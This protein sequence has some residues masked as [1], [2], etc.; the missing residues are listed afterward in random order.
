MIQILGRRR[1]SFHFWQ[2]VVAEIVENFPTQASGG[3]LYGHCRNQNATC[4]CCESHGVDRWEVTTPT[5]LY[6]AK[7]GVSP[8]SIFPG[9]DNLVILAVPAGTQ[10]WTDKLLELQGRQAHSSY[11]CP[12]MWQ[13]DQSGV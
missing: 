3:V 5:G 7:A 11:S 4:S 13:L 12:D 6:S 2:S 1:H 10:G 9:N 8:S